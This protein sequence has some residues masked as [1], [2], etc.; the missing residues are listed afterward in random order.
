[1]TSEFLEEGPWV[2]GW[3]IHCGL[4]EGPGRAEGP[5]ESGDRSC[6]GAWMFSLMG[7]HFSLSHIQTQKERESLQTRAVFL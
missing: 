3:G 4:L 2:D 6:S 5:A 7:E 1:M